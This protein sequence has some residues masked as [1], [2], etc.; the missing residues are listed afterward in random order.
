[1]AQIDEEAIHKLVAARYMLLRGEGGGKNAHPYLSTPVLAAPLVESRLVPTM[2]S[3][4]WGRIYY[5]PEFV[6]K[7]SIQ[8]LRTVVLEEVEHYLKDHH[9]RLKNYPPEIANV[10]ADAELHDNYRD[11]GL[12]LPEGAI[13]PGTLGMPEHLLAEEYCTHLMKNAHRLKVVIVAE[14]DDGQDHGSGSSR[15]SDQSRRQA[16]GQN[17]SGSQSTADQHATTS[18]QQQVS[19]GGSSQSNSQQQGSGR[20]QQR[21]PGGSRRGSQETSSQLQGQSGQQQTES[22]DPGQGGKTPRYYVEVYENDELIARFPFEGTA[23]SS[24]QGPWEAPP[25]DKSDVPGI[26]PAEKELIKRATAAAIREHIK[27]KGSVPGHWQRWADSILE[28]PKVPWQRVLAS[29]LRMAIAYV[30]GKADYTYYK[31]NRRQAMRPDVILPG[32]VQPI[33]NIAV[34]LDTSGSISEDDLRNATSEVAGILRSTAGM[35]PITV[36]A[37]DAQVHSITPVLQIHDL[38]GKILGGGGTDLGVGIERASRLHPKPHII[39]VIT[40]GWTDWPEVP[41]H[42]VKVIVC[43]LPGGKDTVPGW[44]SKIIME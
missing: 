17:Q 24:M 12:P 6:N 1:M 31:Q 10:G 33:P 35:A 44:A 26:S 2:A 16:D 19:S 3:D 23:N 27:N 38:K 7:V 15:S 41:P 42:G 40:D 20:Q 4:R 5:N 29:S 18:Q 8:E 22:A 21:S 28:P 39:V 14:Y 25:P 34:V 32:M 30:R 11:C 9:E 36:L 43:I 37:T 13:Y